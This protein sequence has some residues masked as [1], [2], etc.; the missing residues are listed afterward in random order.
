NLIRTAK[1][2]PPCLRSLLAFVGLRRLATRL[3]LCRV[4]LAAERAETGQLPLAHALH[5]LF[6]LLARLHQAVDFL[7]RRPRPASDPLTPWAVDHA[8]E[9]TLLRRHRENDRLDASELPLVHLIEAVELLAQTRYE[10]EQTLDRPHAADHSICLQEIVEAEL[11]L[12]HAGLELFLLVFGDR[13]L[14][15]LDQRQ[16]VAHAEDAR[17]HPVGMEVLELVELLADGDELDR[18]TRD[19]L[20]GQRRAATRVAVQLGH[21]NSVEGDPLLERERDVHGFLTGHRVEHEQ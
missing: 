13:L 18:A 16:D 11:T 19:R 17:R 5:E 3:L 12:Q 21:Q 8:R 20:H 14:R 15:A 10:L 2:L 1:P 9:R 6:H 4:R 7:H